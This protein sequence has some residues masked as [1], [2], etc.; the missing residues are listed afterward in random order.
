MGL[1]A[2]VSHWLRTNLQTPHWFRTGSA[3]VANIKRE[4]ILKPCSAQ[5]S[6]TQPRPARSSPAQ[7]SPSKPSPALPSFAKPS[8]AQPSP[9]HHKPAQANAAQPN[10]ARHR[11]AQLPKKLAR[12]EPIGPC[13][14]IGV[15]ICT[16]TVNIYIY[17]YILYV[18][19]GRFSSSEPNRGRVSWN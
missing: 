4:T 13:I 6:P 7:P 8:P 15:D 9:T 5:P 16:Y 1:P 18:C 10:T 19:M 14:Y 2:L 17:R 11:L 3:L 12:L